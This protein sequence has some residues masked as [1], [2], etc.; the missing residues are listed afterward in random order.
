MPK[1]SSVRDPDLQ[2]MSQTLTYS[3]ARQLSQLAPQEQKVQVRAGL[4]LDRSCRN[5]HQQY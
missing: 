4:V 3:T 2:R 5:L 1:V